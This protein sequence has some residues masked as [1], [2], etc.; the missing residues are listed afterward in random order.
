MQNIEGIPQQA[1]AAADGT[2]APEPR[3]SLGFAAT[4]EAAT[5][6]DSRGAGKT[7]VHEVDGGEAV[8]AAASDP[9]L[10]NG[11]GRLAC[12]VKGSGMCMDG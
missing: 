9:S 1:Q 5:A 7:G 2:A 10:R 4:I 3:A 6:S 8:H 11:E 12:S